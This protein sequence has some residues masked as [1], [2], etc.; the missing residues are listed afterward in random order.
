[1]TDHATAMTERSSYPGQGL[2]RRRRTERAKPARRGAE[3]PEELGGGGRGTGD[4]STEAQFR[5]VGPRRERYLVAATPSLSRGFTDEQSLLADLEADQAVTV[6]RI[7][8]SGFG[9]SDADRG[10]GFPTIAVVEMDADHAARYAT[11]PGLHVEPDLPLQYAQP[12]PW[13]GIAATDPAVAPLSGQETVTFA[14]QNTDGTPLPGAEVYL[15]STVL[16]A[17]GVT[18]TDGRVSLSVSVDALTGARGVCVRPRSNHWSVWLGNPDLTTATGNLITCPQLRETIPG[19]P[20]QDLNPWARRAMRLDALPPIFRGHGIKVGIIDSGVSANHPDLSGRIAGGRDIVG[21]DDEGW[22]TDIV[23]LG[24]HCAGIIGGSDS[25]SGIVGIAPEVEVHACKIMPGGRFGDLLEA[26]DYC[27]A[28]EIDL[29]HLGVGNPQHSALVALKIEQA[30][31]AGIA[32]IAAAGNSAG[33]V[34]FPASLPSVLA[35]AAIGRIGT[36]PPDSYHATQLYGVPSPEG[37]F[38]AKF[39]AFG[40][41][42]DVCAPGVAIVSAVPPRDYGALDSTSVAAS[43]V[44]ALAALLLAHHPDFREQA[45]VGSAARV[46][47]LFQIIRSSSRPVAIGDPS[48]TGAGI[49]DAVLAFGLLSPIALQAAINPALSSLWSVMAQSGLAPATVPV[50]PATP[51]VPSAE[52]PTGGDQPMG[53]LLPDQPEE[54]LA[55]L[56]S[57]MRAAGLLI[58]TPQP[59]GEKT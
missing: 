13:D 17:Y 48:R 7:I 41:T 15:F 2:T 4:E 47:R 32:C 50:A 37:Y 46:D 33:L 6:L 19:F 14:V 44:T 28:H 55:F 21:Q 42:V 26:L 49:P 30:R 35:V 16:P 59:G 5:P 18:G 23:G 54:S 3:E 11:T 45:L 27:L 51:T 29:V 40:S 24:S 8:R 9:G 39:T 57:A 36:F 10:L 43:Y 22:Q 1:M 38:S 12:A 34:A 25:G 53:G 52:F 31:S 20:R 56:R 58:P